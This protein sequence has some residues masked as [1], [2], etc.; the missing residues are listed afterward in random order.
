V[1]LY[2]GLGTVVLGGLALSTLFSL[3]VVPPMFSMMIGAKVHLSQWLFG[4]ESLGGRAAA[5]V[6]GTL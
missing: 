1:E 6:E 4:R 3:F 5:A 2:R